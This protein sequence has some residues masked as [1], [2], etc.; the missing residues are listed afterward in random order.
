MGIDPDLGL[1][2]VRELAGKVAEAFAE[3]AAAPDVVALGRDLPS[4]LV[5]I[6]AE[7]AVRCRRLLDAGP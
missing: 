7:R 5:D 6:I 4:R 1:H 2:R 3:A